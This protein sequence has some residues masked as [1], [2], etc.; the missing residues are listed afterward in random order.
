MKPTA[1]LI[2][3][4]RGRN[5]DEEALYDA[6]KAGNLAGAGIDVY[7]EEPA[8]EGKEFKCKLRALDNVVVTPHLGASTVEAQQK[9]SIELAHVIIDY[10]VYGNFSGAVNVGENIEFEKKLFYPLFIYHMDK[11][12]MFAKI[13]K[14]LADYCVNI[15][16]NPSRQIGEGYAIAVYLVHQKIEEKVLDELNKI[17]GVIRATT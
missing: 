8:E 5:V 17:D 15:R 16:E 4:A 14:V 7:E 13:D 11:P 6:L 3:T 10:L 1:Y 12:G 2:N 9:T